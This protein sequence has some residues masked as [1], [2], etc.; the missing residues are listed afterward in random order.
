MMRLNAEMIGRESYTR[1]SCS[2]RSIHGC[3]SSI[4]ISFHTAFACLEMDGALSRSSSPIPPPYPLI[5][6]PTPRYPRVKSARKRMHGF[7]RHVVQPTSRVLALCRRARVDSF[8]CDSDTPINALGVTSLLECPSMFGHRV[9]EAR[10]LDVERARA[11]VHVDYQIPVC[12]ARGS[13]EPLPFLKTRTESERI[14]G[15]SGRRKQAFSPSMP[16]YEACV[17]TMR[18]KAEIFGRGI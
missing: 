15:Q 4:P 5:L 7:L 2:A 10:A 11:D 17:V 8:I 1:F 12:R 3:L 9:T 6:Y 14:F 16:V 13:G 18:L